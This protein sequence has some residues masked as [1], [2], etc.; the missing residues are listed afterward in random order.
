MGGKKIVCKECG[1]GHNVFYS[2]GHSHCPICQSIK[3]EQWIDKLKAELLKV[4]YV[5]MI[6]TM[7]HELNGLARNNKKIIYSMIMKSSWQTVKELSANKK[8]IGGLPGMISVLHTFGSDMKY[9][10][11]SHCLV[12]FGG[13]DEHNKWIYP[14]RKYKIAQYRK[15]NSTFKRIFL[16]ALGIAYRRGNIKYYLSYEEVQEMLGE[17]QWVVHNTKPTMETKTLENYLAR[18]INR[19]AISNNRVTYIKS[20]KKVK[21]LYNDYKNQKEGKPAPKK[22]KE[23]SPMIFIDQ[24]MQHVLPPYFQKSRRYGLHS[25]AT[26][27]RLK[28]E[29]PDSIKRNGQ[30][31]RKIMEIITEMMKENPM[32]CECCGAKNFEVEAI[33]SDKELLNQYISIPKCRSPNVKQS[34]S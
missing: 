12:T 6:F 29:L 23:M 2:C 26:K 24:F 1:H 11:H 16:K 4:P 19:I 13:L 7:P 25:N 9:H 20:Q 3:R 15:I 18:Y 28:E 33:Q 32:K 21:I 30:V 5:H 8:N 22:K 31:I 27:K 17:K 34:M 10:I 14:K